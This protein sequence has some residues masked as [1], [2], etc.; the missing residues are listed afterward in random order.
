MAKLRALVNR[1]I[2]ERQLERKQQKKPSLTPKERNARILRRKA[3]DDRRRKAIYA[4]VP[5]QLSTAERMA[6][7]WERLN[8]A[9]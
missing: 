8:H 3:E 1:S 2:Y 9:A 4:H 5:R 6:K 7:A